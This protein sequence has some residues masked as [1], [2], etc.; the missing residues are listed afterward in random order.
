MHAFGGVT[1][2]A[3]R[4]DKQTRPTCEQRCNCA[5]SAESQWAHGEGAAALRIARLHAA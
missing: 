4:V 1:A 2:H 3:V 5:A